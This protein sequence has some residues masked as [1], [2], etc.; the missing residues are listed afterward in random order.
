MVLDVSQKKK[1]YRRTRNV[2]MYGCFSQFIYGHRLYEHWRI[3]DDGNSSN[4]T[5]IFILLYLIRSITP[6]FAEFILIWW[7]AKV[8][9]I[10][11]TFVNVPVN[12]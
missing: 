10:I 12:S 5:K 8:N 3:D 7:S 11:S 4:S 1:K 9:F 2:Y 6:F